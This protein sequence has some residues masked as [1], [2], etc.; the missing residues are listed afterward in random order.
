VT[1]QPQL[2]PWL[3]FLEYYNQTSNKTRMTSYDEIKGRRGTK[4]RMVAGAKAGWIAWLD[5]VKGVRGTRPYIITADPND[6]HENLISTYCERFS[7]VVMSDL[8]NYVEAAM[9][10]Y[11]KLEVEMEKL[12]RMLAQ[13]GIPANTEQFAGALQKKVVAAKL[14]MKAK[15]IAPVQVSWIDPA[16][17]AT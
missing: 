1:L 16:A 14:R 12:A 10:Q 6:E 3:E 13:T 5:K 8:T 9:M 4:I 15:H 2:M 7:Y 17:M 11:P